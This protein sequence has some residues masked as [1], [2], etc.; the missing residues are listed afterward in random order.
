MDRIQGVNRSPTLAAL[1]VYVLALSACGASAPPVAPTPAT[2]ATSTASPSPSATAS[3]TA[4][5]SPLPPSYDAAYRQLLERMVSVDTSHGNETRLLEP[6]AALYRAAG[7]PVQI[8]ESAPGRGNLVARLK[9][10]GAKR[11]LLLLAHVDVVPVEGQPWTVPAFG[12]TQKD[13]FLWGRGIN[14]DKG[15]AAAI[16]AL[17]LELAST[18]AALTR[19]VIVALTAGEET[20]GSAG[21]RWLAENHK[22]LLDAEIALNEGGGMLLTDDF[23]RPIAVSVGVS[24]KVFQTFQLVVKG[25][26][27][28]SSRPPTSGDP[29]VALARALVKVG[30]HR[31]AATVLPEAK[32]DFATELATAEPEYVAALRNAVASAP[33]LSAA[34]DAILSKDPGYNATV[35]TTCV[36][37]MLKG[38]PQ[39]N[40]LPTTA[41]AT[42]NCRILPGETRAEV[43]AALAEAIGDPNVAIG[44][45]PN[46]GDAAASPFEGEVVLAVKAV[47]ASSFPGTPVVPGMSTGA[48]DSRH[49]RAIGIRAY[50]VSPGTFTRAEGRAGHGAHGP[51]ERR[52]VKWLAPG[53]D[54][55]RAIVR[56]LVL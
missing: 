42:I 14:D 44:D 21:A 46:I 47:M 3:A 1:Y 33:R 28:H 39:D 49:L 43:R 55:F 31:F 26:G 16:V 9:G 18:H 23:A 41:E 32:A 36:T 56:A 52:S 12:V 34:D 37:T 7:V 17:T 48:T 53:A 11:P 38:S 50:G 15:M 2:T 19:D 25:K 8:L 30:E 4:T 10:S 5:E 40:V 13:G 6:I 35:R 27:G 51:D 24:E 20:G 45:G 29:V 22:E 54:A